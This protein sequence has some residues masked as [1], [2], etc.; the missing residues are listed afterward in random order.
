V[1][2]LIIG[3]AGFVGSEIVRQ[4]NFKEHGKLIILDK[5]VGKISTMSISY[6]NYKFISG[7]ASDINLLTTILEENS[8]LVTFR[9]ALKL[10]ILI[11]KI[12]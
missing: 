3:G 10:Q 11:F 8:V 9:A 7:E 5:N 6:P 12:P 1:N 2:T 4:W